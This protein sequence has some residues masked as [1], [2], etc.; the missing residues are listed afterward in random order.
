MRTPDSEGTLLDTRCR[1]ET[2][3]GIELA[4]SPA[5]VV[6]R[7]YAFIIDFGIRLIVF[8]IVAM[9]LGQLGAFGVG[10]TLASFFLIEWLFPVVFELS[11][12]AATPGKRALGLRVVMDSG[13]PVT[14]AA[15][16]TRN[17]LRAAD[18]MPL[19]YAAGMVTMLFRHDFKRLGDI[20][21]GTLVVHEALPPVAHTL[22]DATPR[23]P[24]ERLSV[25][26]QSAVIDWAGRLPRLTAARAEELASIAAPRVVPRAPSEQRVGALVGVAHWLMGER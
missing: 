12:W 13:L 15:S 11:G 24:A 19:A 10:L 6:A 16:L 4:L 23:P 8:A 20:A 7:S 2:P 9:T 14:A 1:V 3:E 5:G 22:V 18:F 17:L 26:A 21:A 25:R